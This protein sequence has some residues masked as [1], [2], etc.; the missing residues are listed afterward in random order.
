[1]GKHKDSSGRC[2]CTNKSLTVALVMIAIQITTVCTLILLG[3]VF[4][5]NEF[6]SFGPNDNLRIADYE[7]NTHLRY[8]LA[9]LFIIILGLIVSLGDY[10]SKNY[11][12]DLHLK[13][14]YL[15]FVVVVFYRMSYLFVRAMSFLV[16]ISQLAFTIVNVIASSLLP[17]FEL[18]IRVMHPKEHKKHHSSRS[19]LSDLNERV[20]RLEKALKSQVPVDSQSVQQ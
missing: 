15:T 5:N 2:C 19:Q 20:H 1:M 4:G 12:D 16:M 7:V 13:S 8:G 18:Y 3:S 6:V 14:P 10:V 11:I 9:M 17:L